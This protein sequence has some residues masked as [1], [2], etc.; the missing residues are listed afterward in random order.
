MRGL[1]CVP[2][3]G[4]FPYQFVAAWPQLLFNTKPLCEALDFRLVGSSLIYDAREQAAKYMLKEGYDWLFFLDSDMEPRPDTI[5]RLLAWDVPIVSAM[6]FK[7][8]QPY[9]PCFYPEVKFD[10][11]KAELRTADDWTEGLAEVEGVGMACCLIKNEVFKQTPQPWFF[12]MPVLAE[13]LGFCK[14]AR[15]AGF[16]VYVDTSFYCGH[17]GTD[18]ITDKHYQ[19]YRRLYGSNRNDAGQK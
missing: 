17:V 15:E 8:T 13:D 14:R 2:H 18:V 7:R 11:E 16:K 6:A 10:G 12:P 5:Q 9:S 4:H 19:E 3:T 1:I